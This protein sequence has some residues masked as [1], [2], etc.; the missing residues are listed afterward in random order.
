[1]KAAWIL[2]TMLLAWPAAAAQFGVPISDLSD[3]AWSE[4][5]GDADA[6]HFDEMDEGISS[7][8]DATTSWRSANNPSADMLSS[9]IT[10]LTDP[11]DDTGHVLRVRAAKSAAGG[12]T[13]D[14][15]FRIEQGGSTIHATCNDTSNN[16]ISETWTTYSVTLPTSC[17]SLI[18]DYG[19][20]EI[21]V[22]GNF[23]GTGG[24]R[25]LLLSTS[26]LEIPGDAAG[27]VF[28]LNSFFGFALPSTY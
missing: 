1:M 4:N 11:S 22:E 27:G 12:R 2:F 17:T 7:T 5:A 6:D 18:S 10:S 15:D 14:I 3:G 28:T 23:G 20:L 24:G 25:R 8:D 21:V 13:I 9:N 26:E 16:A 19:D